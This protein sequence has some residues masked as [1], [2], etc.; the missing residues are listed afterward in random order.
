MS[1][2]NKIGEMVWMDLTVDNAG[3]VKGFYQSVIGWKSTDI[4][5]NKGQY[6][7]YSM[8]I[9]S[10]NQAIT[11][12][13]HAKGPNADMP[14]AWIPYFL[15]ADIDESVAQVASQRG[16]LVTPI[17]TIG[18]DKYVVIKDPAGAVCALYQKNCQ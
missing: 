7:D 14:A 17:K 5:M 3:E 12:I 4:A 9:S 15:V 11:G 6:N 18:S 2:E 8:N 1:E 16:E 10:T 13:C